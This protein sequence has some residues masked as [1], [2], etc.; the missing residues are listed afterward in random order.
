MAKPSK[1]GGIDLGLEGWITRKLLIRE[2]REEN[3]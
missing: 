1:E 3:S 2:G